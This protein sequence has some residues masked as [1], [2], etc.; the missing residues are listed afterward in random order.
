ML[1]KRL[2]SYMIFAVVVASVGLVALVFVLMD[3][4]RRGLDRWMK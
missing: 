1:F 3:C 4:A 2:V